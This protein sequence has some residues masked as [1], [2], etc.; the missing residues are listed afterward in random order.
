MKAQVALRSTASRQRSGPTQGARPV[1]LPHRALMVARF[2]SKAAHVPAVTGPAVAEALRRKGAEA[3]TFEGVVLVP[4]ERVGPDC[5][6]HEVSHALQQLAGGADPVGAA[7]DPPALLERL[8][9]APVMPAEAPVEVLARSN[10]NTADAVVSTEPAAAPPDAVSLRRTEDVPANDV[11]EPPAPRPRA[12]ISAGPDATTS[13]EGADPSTETASS[14]PEA[15]VT[16]IAPTFAPPEF[17]EPTLD[18]AV[19]AERAAAA[20]AAQQAMAAADDPSAVME[21][22]ATMAPSQQA[23]VMPNIGAR[24]GEAA[25]TSNA[26]LGEATPEVAVNTRGGEG[27]MPMPPPVAIPADAPTIE[28]GEAAEPTVMVP[29]G[30]EQPVLRVDPGY[31]PQIERRFTESSTPERVEESVD[32]VSTTNPG[33]ETRVPDRADVPRD[34]ANDPQRLDEALTAQR[35]EASAL[36]QQAAQ[37][38]VDGPGPE[39]IQPR[40]LEA[41]APPPEFPPPV[42]EGVAPAPEAAQLQQM[43]LPEAVVASFDTAATDQMAASARAARDEMQTAEATR[44]TAHQTAVQ[45]AET[46]RVEAEQ[47]ADQS[48]RDAVSRQRQNIQTERQRT[49]DDQNQRMAEVNAEAAQA[50]GEKRREAERTAAD[51]QRQI[52]GRYDQAERDAEAEIRAGEQRA[53]AERER[54]KREAA[55]ASWWERAVNFIRDAF[56]ALVSLVNRIFDAVR[57]AVTGLIDLARRAVVGLI[58]L[59]S[60][61]LQAIVSALGEVLKGLVDGLIGQIFPELAARLNAAIDSAVNTVNSAID[62]IAQVLTDA[63]NAIAAALTSAVNALLDVFQGALNTALAVLE[64]ALTGDWGLLLRR[65][66]EAVL[67]VL[68]IDPA[69]FYALIE[70]A[71]DAITIIV[72]DPGQFVSNMIDVVVGGVRLFMEHFPDH[73]RRGIIGWLT[74]ALGDIQIPNEWNIWTILDLARQILGLTWDFVRER[75]ARIIGPENVARIE[76]M[77]SWIGT[78][79]TEGWQGLWNR[80]QESL[81]SLRDSVLEMIRNFVLERVVMAAITWLASLFNPVGAIVKLVMTIWNIYQF[82]RAQLQ[83]LMGIAQAVVGAISN[84]AHGV[85]EPGQRAVESVLGN[86][87]PVVIDLLMSLLGVTGVAARVRQIIQDLRQRIA[88][89]VDRMLQ[90]VL[91]TLG[92]GRGGAAAERDA[93]AAAAAAGPQPGQIGHPVVVDVAQGPDH[94]LTVERSGAGGATIMLRT[95]PRPLA[96]WLNTLSGQATNLP[97]AA[98]RNEATEKIGQVRTLLQQLDPVADRAASVAPSSGGA[99]GAPQSASD[100]AAVNS[101]EDRIALPLRQAFDAVGGAAATGEVKSAAIDALRQAF[102]QVRPGTVEVVRARTNAIKSEFASRGLTGLQVA[103]APA[104][105]IQISASASAPQTVTVGFNEVFSAPSLQ[106]NKSLFTDIVSTFVGEAR[107]SETLAVVSVNGIALGGERN[108]AQHAEQ[109]LIASPAWQQA[110]DRAD[111]LG[112]ESQP[113]DLVISLNRSP[114]KAVCTDVLSRWLRNNR[115]NHPNVRFTI[116]AT[117]RYSPSVSKE[118]LLTQMLETLDA[119][120]RNVTLPFAVMEAEPRSQVEHWFDQVM[121]SLMRSA[122]LRDDEITNQ[123]DLA[124]LSGAGWRLL[125]LQVVENVTPAR[126]ALASML[127][128]LGQQLGQALRVE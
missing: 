42:T 100:V 95:E 85:L 11:A 19:A 83:R 60:Q 5:V 84:I 35:D 97:D 107:G 36:R 109:Q 87:V 40:A 37:A 54:K 24:L 46:K 25:A 91:Q 53:E 62:G 92:F 18:P 116:A 29:E 75:A 69:A 96:E 118:H 44:D 67:N 31:G 38:V 16:D 104:G 71:A 7:I 80:I 111:E 64:A 48:Q 82:V 57:S 103:G 76:M 121:G 58:E 119:L 98:R 15:P 86:L 112:T 56:N 120:G 117:S 70:Q 22:Y 27:P 94:T 124:Q 45:D 68:G 78:L 74:G 113:A 79:I 77:A 28:L 72:N 102:N 101:L 55:E 26:R 47:T 123:D 10:E 20:E 61:A 2:G 4:D 73:F 21:A 127:T 52:D 59:A 8:A 9:H 3:A 43:A 106:P 39:R 105:Q 128:Q 23:Q 125:Q 126:G 90:R 88:D 6:A 115:R 81:A 13:V 14:A 63:V 50:R 12:E 114:C 51:H 17:V 1:T 65:I 99:G 33:I 108:A 110:L 41:S 93:V 34:G 66:L 32:A 49:V 30:P 89:A 122:T